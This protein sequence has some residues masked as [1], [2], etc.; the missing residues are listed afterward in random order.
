M[1]DFMIQKGDLMFSAWHRNARDI[2]INVCISR[3]EIF[4]RLVGSRDLKPY[5]NGFF[6]ISRAL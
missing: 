4:V 6:F 5:T 3:F 2:D 1:N